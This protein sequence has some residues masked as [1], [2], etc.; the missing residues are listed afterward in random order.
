MA[1]I[2]KPTY[3]RVVPDDAEIFVRGGKRHAR[4]KGKDGRKVTAPIVVAKQNKKDPRER[5]LME[6][7]CWYYR[8]SLGGREFKGKG[9]KDKEATR[10]LE[11]RK[12]REAAYENGTGIV[13]PYKE[14]RQRQLTE[15]LVDY[16]QY[17]RDKEEVVIESPAIGLTLEY[18]LSHPATV[19]L[20]SAGGFTREQLCTQIANAYQHVYHEEARKRMENSASWGTAWTS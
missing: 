12:K 7:E 8:F 2:F 13:D 3:S 6:S 4:F 17:L 18:P 11:A 9:F 20:T 5:C 19:H 1:T 10:Q 16:Q 14:H 15:H